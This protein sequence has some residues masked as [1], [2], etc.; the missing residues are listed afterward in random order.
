MRAVACFSAGRISTRRLR[1][2]TQGRQGG[3]HEQRIQTVAGNSE[4]RR[5]A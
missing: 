3:E 2:E 5:I 4:E 1:D